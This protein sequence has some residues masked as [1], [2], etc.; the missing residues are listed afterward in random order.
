MNLFINL[1]KGSEIVSAVIEH[2][3]ENSISSAYISAIGAVSEAEIGFYDFEKKE[4]YFKK[5]EEDLELINL[6]GNIALFNGS[7]VF[8]A[9]ATL[10]DPD[11]N[12]IGGHLKSAIVSG[13]CEIFITVLDKQLERAHD[14]DSGLNL[15]Q[16]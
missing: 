11:Y 1:K 13:A 7:I 8:H 4:Y 5:F 3:K 14:K 12:V 15:I 16:S 9:H 2:C 6:T 10:A